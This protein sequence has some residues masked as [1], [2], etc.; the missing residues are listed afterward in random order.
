MGRSNARMYIFPAIT[1]LIPALQRTEAGEP[2]SSDPQGEPFWSEP[3]L[4]IRAISLPSSYISYVP[5][6]F[7]LRPTLILRLSEAS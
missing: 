1:L 5:Q 4:R 3:V 6:S 2:S 7:P